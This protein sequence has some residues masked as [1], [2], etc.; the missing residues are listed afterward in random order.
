MALPHGRGS[1]GLVI[2]GLVPIV[3]KVIPSF[4]FMVRRNKKRSL[5][6]ASFA[7]ANYGQKET[8]ASLGSGLSGHSSGQKPTTMHLSLTTFSINS[9]TLIRAP[10]ND[11]K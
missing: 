8:F 5:K 6:T 9:N 4:G 10:K 3:L 11:L 7:V 1:M 2:C